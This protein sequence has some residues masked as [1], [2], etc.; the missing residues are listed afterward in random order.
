LRSTKQNR[1]RILDN[2]LAFEGEQQD[3][4]NQQRGDRYWRQEMQ[5]PIAKPVF[6]LVPDYPL[7]RQV[8]RDER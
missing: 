8:A 2:G 7:A 1:Q 5:E 6:T 3:Q 4:R